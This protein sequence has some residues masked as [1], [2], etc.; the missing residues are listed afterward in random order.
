MNG[1]FR[2]EPRSGISRLVPRGMFS[3]SQRPIG[4]RGG[5]CVFPPDAFGHDDEVLPRA[6]ALG[7]LRLGKTQ[8]FRQLRLR[9][10][11]RPHATGFGRKHALPP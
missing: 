5:E 9:L 8:D 11:N 7:T 3:I 6:D 1:T 4:M 10:G 2:V